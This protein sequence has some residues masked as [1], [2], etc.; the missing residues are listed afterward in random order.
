MSNETQERRT[1]TYDAEAGTITCPYCGETLPLADWTLTETGYARYWDLGYGDDYGESA[2]MV[3]A[4]N[5][6][7]AEDGDDC[8]LAH[9]SETCSELSN[10]PTN[11]EWDWN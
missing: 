8:C 5:D 4:T 7:F 11:F 1:A 9:Y 2:D 3:F 10:T 6:R